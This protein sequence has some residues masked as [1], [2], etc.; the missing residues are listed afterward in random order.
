MLND[1]SNQRSRWK[2]YSYAGQ[3]APSKFHLSLLRSSPDLTSQQQSSDGELLI[4]IPSTC[5]VLCQKMK[6]Y[7]VT[8]KRFINHG[9]KNVT[10][11]KQ[12]WNVWVFPRDA[13]SI[14]ITLP[15]FSFPCAIPH[16]LHKLSWTQLIIQDVQS[17]YDLLP[18]GW[19]SSQGGSDWSH[20][21]WPK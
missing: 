13:T 1:I 6:S 15:F 7:T 9:W 5:I 12:F 3:G 16:H 8:V 19:V 14:I 18:L 20:G 17:W 2:D 10:V 4:F 11:T 21:C